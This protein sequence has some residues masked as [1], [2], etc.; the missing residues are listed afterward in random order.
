[1]KIFVKT[2]K[3]L[4]KLGEGKIFSKNQLMLREFSQNGVTAVANPDGQNHTASQMLS[5]ARRI[6]Q[7]PG[8]KTVVMSSADTGIGAT[9][10]VPS[11]SPLSDVK[12]IIP[13]NKANDSVISQL[14]ADGQGEVEL[15]SDSNANNSALE[16]NSVKPRKVMDEMRRNSIPFTKKELS[17]FLNSL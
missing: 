13:L 2:D 1:M 6:A 10:N 7:K 9:K 15:T 11:N 16:T 5:N 17:M 8:V 4:K 14:T 3:G 12:K